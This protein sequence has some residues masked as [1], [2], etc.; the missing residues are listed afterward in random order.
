MKKKIFLSIVC[1]IIIS[2]CVRDEK[3]EGFPLEKPKIV[4]NSFL[5]NDLPIEF[6][7]SKSLSSIDNA[8]IKKIS[9]AEIKIYENDKLIEVINQ[10]S[11]NPLNTIDAYYKSIIT[12]KIGNFYK[13]SVSAPK[14]ITV[15]AESNLPSQLKNVTAKTGKM[16]T[17]IRIYGSSEYEDSAN[18]FLNIMAGNI[19]LSIPDEPNVKNFYKIILQVVSKYW[20]GTKW[21]YRYSNLGLNNNEKDYQNYDNGLFITDKLYDGKNIPVKLDIINHYSFRTADQKLKFRILISSQSEE[22]QKYEISLGQYYQNQNNPFVEP[23]LVYSNIMGGYDI[24]ASESKI[25]IF[26][27]Y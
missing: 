9:N 11:T 8:S 4:V 12:P 17:T 16:D 18:Y 19:P 10:E 13:I 27:E 14:L 22:K 24:F 6:F 3:I 15:T 23:T 26:L 20:D 21:A 1:S 5:K 7:I 25:E 2:S